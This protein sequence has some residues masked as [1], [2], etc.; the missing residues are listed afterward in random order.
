MAL[1]ASG[2]ISA[3]DISREFG[4]VTNISFG[5]YRISQSVGSLSNLPLDTGIPQS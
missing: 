3:S 4:Q 1:Q 2:S 5:A